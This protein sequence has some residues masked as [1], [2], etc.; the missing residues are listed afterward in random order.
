VVFGVSP[1]IVFRRDAGSCT[2]VAPVVFGMESA[3]AKE[4]LSEKRKSK[5]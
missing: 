4:A 1:N 5:D 3:G 2:R